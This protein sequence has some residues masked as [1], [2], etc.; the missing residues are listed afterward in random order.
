MIYSLSDIKK[1]SNNIYKAVVVMGKAAHWF[2]AFKRTTIKNPVYKAI[3]EFID[4]NIEYEL[5]EEED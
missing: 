2:T 1:R 4:G 5:I 3:E